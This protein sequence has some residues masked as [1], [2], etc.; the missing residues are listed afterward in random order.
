MIPYED[1]YYGTS[2]K[3][4]FKPSSP[5]IKKTLYPQ[6]LDQ[7]T[8]LRL[9]N[10]ET[11][12]TIVLHYPTEDIITVTKLSRAEDSYG[13]RDGQDNHTVIIKVSDYLKHYGIFEK[14]PPQETV[15]ELL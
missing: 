10:G 15:K 3:F 5:N 11:T 9:K 12:Q 7:L 6:T 2:T 1:F 13:N 4:N 14:F 8:G